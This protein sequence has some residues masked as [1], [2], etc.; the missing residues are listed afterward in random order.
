MYP[1]N[2]FRNEGSG[3]VVCGGQGLLRRGYCQKL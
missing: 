2:I 3:S 1:L